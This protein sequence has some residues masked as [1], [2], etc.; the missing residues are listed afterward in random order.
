MKLLLI[1]SFIAVI[2]QS[3]TAKVTDGKR[4]L[5]KETNSENDII[6]LV[7]NGGSFTAA[8]GA[9]TF[10]RALQVQK[11]I[12]DGEEMPALDT[13]DY[14]AALSGGN[15]INVPYHYAQNV[16][17]DTLL[18]A[19]G[20][21]HPSEVTMEELSTTP[22]NS[23]FRRYTTPFTPSVVLGAL[24]AFFFG[25]ALW[26][27]I[28]A[29]QV[30]SPYVSPKTLMSDAKIREGVKSKPIVAT[31]MIGPS[32]IHPNWTDTLLN[33]A[34]F[35]EF[36]EKA[37]S[38]LAIIEDI[39]MMEVWNLEEVYDWTEEE[40]AYL[41]SYSRTTNPTFYH[42]D[43]NYMLA[44]AEKYDFKMALPA[45]GTDEDFHIPLSPTGGEGTLTYDVV[46]GIS[47]EPI[48]FDAS[49]V[50]TYEELNKL[51]S[52]DS[53][54]NLEHLIGMGTDVLVLSHDTTE[55]LPIRGLAERP[56]SVTLPFSGRDEKMAFTDGGYNDGTGLPALLS[57][58]PSTIIM[59]ITQSPYDTGIIIG[60]ELAEIIEYHL[61][62]ATMPYFGITD[63]YQPVD[64][65]TAA[66]GPLNHV[67][68]LY[69]NGENQYA[70]LV[71][72]MKALKAAGEPMITTLEGLEVVDNPFWGIEGGWTVDLTVFLNSGVPD[73]F[74]DL[75]PDDVAPAPEGKN[76]TEYG[77]FTN[78]N[79][80]TVPNVLFYDA[81]ESVEVPFLGSVIEIPSIGASLPTTEIRMTELLVDWA[82]DRAWDGLIDADGVERFGGFRKIFEGE[83][84][85]E[86][87]GFGV[88]GADDDDETEVVS[89]KSKKAKKNKAKKTKMKLRK[90]KKS[91]KSGKNR[92]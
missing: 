5:K 63:G 50:A 91:K 34:I 78:A 7:L 30:I 53:P 12:T 42:M 15:L 46:D 26:P 19:E 65:F 64:H 23:I 60:P 4:R 14:I 72:N 75:I 31:S 68:N 57:K 41:N 89:K 90:S 59:P 86:S 58:K 32:A 37:T 1:S 82:V 24:E 81:G 61:Q 43:N 18:D 17:T 27:K 79:F 73:K 74:A 49:L 47:I 88:S 84:D 92:E 45:Y 11:V 40:I 62:Y 2:L 35:N 83:D 9:A 51:A 55:K 67:F 25:G 76:K 71:K 66:N 44:L 39:E 33:R 22:P 20:L 16:D 80:S 56:I 29:N 36:N 85:D 77:Y 6:G 3:S 70:K 38:D 21:S 69:S 52:E 10:L 8:N 87:D 54:F 13:I 48:D 28:V